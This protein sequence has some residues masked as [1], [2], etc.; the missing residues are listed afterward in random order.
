MPWTC[1]KCGVQ[2]GRGTPDHLPPELNVTYRCPVCHLEVMFDP[3]TQKMKPI[4]PRKPTA[5]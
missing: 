1:P 3:V 4:P 2:L 5:A